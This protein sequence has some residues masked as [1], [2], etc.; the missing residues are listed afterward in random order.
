[1]RRLIESINVSAW[2]VFVFA[3]VY[4]FTITM[5]VLFIIFQAIP[6][7]LCYCFFGLFTG[8]T[9]A[10]TYIWRT[11]KKKVEKDLDLPSDEPTI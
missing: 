9:G 8:E 5:I 7:D 11:K 10:L 1:M 2:I 4:L 6:S 3:S